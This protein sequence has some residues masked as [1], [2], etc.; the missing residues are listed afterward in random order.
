[1]ILIH[2]SVNNKPALIDAEN[3]VFVEE[4]EAVDQDNISF[5]R[6]YLKQPILE[7]KWIDVK[8]KVEAIL[9]SITHA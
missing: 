8:E 6:I 4:C 9:Q 3:I 2:L 1:M 5:T 7:E